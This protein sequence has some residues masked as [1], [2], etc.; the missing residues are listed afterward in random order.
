ME[1]S[2]AAS[3][4]LGIVTAALFAYLA[5]ALGRRS[6]APDQRPALNLFRLWWGCL[7]LITVRQV[8][9]VLL[10]HAGLLPVWLYQTFRQ[11]T[12]IAAS[13]AL[14]A[15]LAYLLYVYQGTRRWWAPLGVFY[16]AVAFAMLA[17]V[18]YSRPE[19]LAHGFGSVEAVAAHE[20]PRWVMVPIL[21]AF[22][23]P[24]VVAS[25]AYLRLYRHAPD[26]TTRYR[27]LLVSASLLVWLGATLLAESLDIEADWWE[28]SRRLLGLGAALLVLMAYFPPR[29][30]AAR[31]G[32]RRVG[33]EAA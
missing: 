7:S 12:I 21:V 28:A 18:A 11:G 3:T 9:E 2:L 1:A 20:V 10:L 4:V 8:A 31:M 23:G 5:H 14:W 25:A 16:V 13:V 29:I 15:L 24:Q 33:E 26:A 30:L 6:V 27:V 32:L 17:V 22:L 19:S